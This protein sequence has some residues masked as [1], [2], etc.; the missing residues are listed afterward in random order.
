VKPIGQRNPRVF[1]WYQPETKDIYFDWPVALAKCRLPQ[2]VPVGKLPTKCPEF[3]NQE[4]IRQFTAAHTAVQKTMSLAFARF[5]GDIDFY[6]LDKKPEQA[7]GS[8]QLEL[9]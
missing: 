7:T 2:T 8:A 6:P 5:Q 4:H 3:G 9:F 1:Y